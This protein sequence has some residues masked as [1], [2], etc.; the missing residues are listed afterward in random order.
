MTATEA[1]LNSS[2]LPP[3]AGGG[4]F[5]ATRPP[6]QR[7]LT[8]LVLCLGLLYFLWRVSDVLPPFLIA[9]FLA[10][11]L[12]PFV[13]RMQKRG[14]SRGRAV[15]S[16]YLLVF[17]VLTLVIVVPGRLAME[18]I[19]GFTEEAATYNSNITSAATDLF[20]RYQKP[21]STL[22]IKEKDLSARS[23][24]V[25]DFVRRTLE[26]VKTT[27]LGFAGQLLWFVIIPLSLFYFLLDYQRIRGKMLLLVPVSH[28]PHVDQ[29][30]LEIVEIFAKYIHSLAVVCTLY[31]ITA[32]L[33]FAILHLKYFLFLG[34]AAGVFYSVPYVG[35]LLS[36]GSA[37][38]ITLTMEKH[39]SLFLVLSLFLIM[40]VTFDYGITPRIVGGSVGLHPVINI[41]ALMCGATMFG[42]WGMLLA[43]P[44][45]ASV[46][47][48]LVYFFPRLC[49]EP[50]L[51]TDNLPE[52]VSLVK[53]VELPDPETSETARA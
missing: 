15:A 43:V 8:L 23:G 18:Q 2:P 40:H 21:L 10:S 9:F 26:T 45:A 39:P 47:M 49:D 50:N 20:H 27:I 4:R 7:P 42:V 30:S 19:Q 48:L 5:A 33:L 16:I 37:T 35:P 31:G 14:V 28:R 41:F 32:T 13:T 22:G 25:A 17:G 51:A 29:M 52:N 36:I 3:T 53:T 1:D 24:P 12:D 6:W 46:Q 11:L 44:V 38:A 34:V